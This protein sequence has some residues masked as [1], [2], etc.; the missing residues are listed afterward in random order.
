MMDAVELAK[1]WLSAHE[2]SPGYTICGLSS[3]GRMVEGL[4]AAIERIATERDHA[5]MHR[6]IFKTEM[7]DLR[8]QRDDAKRACDRLIEAADVEDRSNNQVMQ[9]R[10]SYEET[11]TEIHTATGCEREWSNLHD[12]GDCA[13]DQVHNALAELDRRRAEVKT[14]MT[15][16][17]ALKSRNEKLEGFFAEANRIMSAVTGV[18]SFATEDGAPRTVHEPC[19]GDEITGC[20]CGMTPIMDATGKAVSVPVES[21]ARH[22]GREIIALRDRGVCITPE[23]LDAIIAERAEN[24]DDDAF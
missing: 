2:A 8:E 3:T 6:N 1:N 17:V 19:G 18:P 13:L 24:G 7:D 22:T 11:L 12:C 21:P 20:I 5:I 10:D 14:L 16:N 23:Q 4:L 9:E 15:E